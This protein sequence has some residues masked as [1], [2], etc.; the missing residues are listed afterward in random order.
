MILLL[1]IFLPFKPEKVVTK[2]EIIQWW[3]KLN[4]KNKQSLFKDYIQETAT[5]YESYW[6]LRTIELD[7]IRSKSVYSSVTKSWK[8]TTTNQLKEV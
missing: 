7:Q 2:Q 5:D 6:Q 3:M 8:Y 1:A 4:P